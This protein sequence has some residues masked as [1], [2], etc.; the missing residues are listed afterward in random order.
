MRIL[1]TGGAGFIG[2]NFIHMVMNESDHSVVNFDALTYAGNRAGT[3][4]FEGSGR[5]HFVQGDIADRR[6]VEAAIT[7][8][9]VE[10]IV[11][12]AA[13]SHVDRSIHDAGAFI[14]TNIAG[15]QVLLEAARSCAVRRFIQISTDEVYGDLTEDEP[16][17]TERSLIK[18][19]SPYAAS[20]ASADM[21][22]LAAYRTHRQPVLITRCSNNYG[23]YQYPEK[24]VPLA[25]HR[26]RAGKAIPVYGRGTN[27]RDW[28]HVKDHCRGIQ[29]A[30]ERGREG[31][32]YNFGGDSEVRN[33][34]V[35]RSI[36]DI[37][38]RPHEL[39]RFVDDRPGHD[40]RYAI[41]FSKAR[42]QLKWKP[43]RNFKDGLVDTVEWYASSG[44]W[45]ECVISEH[46]EEF[47]Q[48]LYGDLA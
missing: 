34:D 28:I 26:A 23:P 41:D 44:A 35:V 6:A 37:T 7:D 10:A 43:E 21:L 36:L 27:I 5:Y 19:S 14:H 12:F 11:N 16:C 31:E 22:V 25:I 30:L 33:I 48:K 45:L 15:T 32:V 46:Y 40:L 20:K 4:S 39:I 3:E 2:T 47:S 8:Y 38:E 13:E 18:P 1:V 17:F 24:L 29:C 42:D 9:G